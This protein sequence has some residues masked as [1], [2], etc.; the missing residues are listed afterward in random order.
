[1][2]KPSLQL[3]LAEATARY[4]LPDLIPAIS[5][6]ISQQTGSTPPDNV[7]LQIWH[8][9][10]IQQKLYHNKDRQAPQTL[11]AIPLLTTN[12]YGLYDSVIVSLKLES[13]WPNCG[14]QGHSVIQLRIIFCP[15]QC[16]FFAAYIQRFNVALRS[17]PGGVSPVTGMH[18]L[19][20][21]PLCT[22]A[23]SGSLYLLL[24]CRGS[25]GCTCVITNQPADKTM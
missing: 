5:A 22:V 1:M 11:R 18:H 23:T 2:T 3:T 4:K 16:N 17:N 25:G 13:D 12:P 6:F 8:T 19:R 15:L 9:L 24:H 14:L 7:K 21:C 20:S 10:R